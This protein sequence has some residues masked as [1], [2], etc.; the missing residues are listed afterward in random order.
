MKI[1]NV[2]LI[3]DNKVDNFINN[4][5][6]SKSKVASNIMVKNSGVEALDFLETVR[7]DYSKF[8]DLVFLDISMPIMDGFEFLDEFINFP[9][10]KENRCSV[11]MLTSSSNK[12]DFDR[13]FKYGTVKDYFVKPLTNKMLE[14]FFINQS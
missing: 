14:E 13:A 8:P 2:L 3:D 11:I 1:N 4:H 7:D 6:I 12:N 9:K 10:V 5:I